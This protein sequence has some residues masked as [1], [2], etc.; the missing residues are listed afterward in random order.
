MIA[1]SA[2]RSSEITRRSSAVIAQKCA[3]DSSFTAHR[4]S[5][6]LI[7]ETLTRVSESATLHALGKLI[8][9]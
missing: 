8:E 7:A 3:I 1:N 4:H 5:R 9:R 6:P 2:R